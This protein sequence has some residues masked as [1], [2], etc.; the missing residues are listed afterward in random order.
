MDTL[1]GMTNL[2]T[3]ER[4]VALAH[5]RLHELG[6]D[7]G[8]LGLGDPVMVRQWKYDSNEVVYLLPY[9]EVRWQATNRYLAVSMGISGVTSNVVEFDHNIPPDVLH[10]TAAGRL[11]APTPT[12]YLQMLGL[13]INVN[14]LPHDYE[15]RE[16]LLRES[17]TNSPAVR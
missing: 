1:A 11:A 5:A 13:P 6:L 14:F 16:R 8:Q 17:Q 15:R 4:A 3:V 7:D 12:N 10:G 2:L 9:Y